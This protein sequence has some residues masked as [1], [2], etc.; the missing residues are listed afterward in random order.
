MVQATHFEPPPLSS[1]PAKYRRCGA[2]A[3]PELGYHF[4][5]SNNSHAFDDYST[6][7]LVSAGPESG[8]SREKQA[9]GGPAVLDG[10]RIFAS[11][12]TIHTNGRKRGQVAR[13]Q[14][15]FVEVL[16]QYVMLCDA[17]SIQGWVGRWLT[18]KRGRIPWQCR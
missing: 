12:L 6:H 18:L 8:Y 7:E 10:V 17:E 2:Q 3:S 4:F 13:A 11:G 9:R 5:S 15:H 1:S 14:N 16:N